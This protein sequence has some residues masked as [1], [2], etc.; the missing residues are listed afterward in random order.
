MSV[1]TAQQLAA[2]AASMGSYARVTITTVKGSK[3]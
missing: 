3:K 2:I 1:S